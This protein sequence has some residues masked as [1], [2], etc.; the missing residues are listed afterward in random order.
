[1]YQ[2]EGTTDLAMSQ[3][4][5]HDDTLCVIEDEGDRYVAM[6]P[7][8]AMLD[9]KWH[10][11]RE[12]IMRDPVLS[13]VIRMIRTTGFDGKS[14]QMVC[15]PLEYL[16][17]WLFKLDVSRYEGDR[18]EKIIE[19]QTECYQVLY[20]HFFGDPRQMYLSM[21]EMQEKIARLELMI[22]PEVPIEIFHFT[23]MIVRMF[24]VYDQPGL[25]AP[26]II[27]ILERN[28]SANYSQSPSQLERLG[29]KRDKHFLVTNV[30]KVAAH[31][32]LTPNYLLARA[33]LGGSVRGMT[34]VLPHGMS[35]L[36][37]VAPDLYQWYCNTVYPAIPRA[38]RIYDHRQDNLALTEGGSK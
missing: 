33:R 10:A 14:Y 7:I 28:W 3:V 30:G 9:L 16:N 18:R 38:G 32:G 6:K 26:D 22:S 12:L 13:S 34:F 37:T 17:G 5:F 1:M 29:L 21:V 25:Y 20:R 35:L 8:C 27:H 19:Y 2:T 23:D 11:Q 4:K 15:L 24:M 36:R 31:L